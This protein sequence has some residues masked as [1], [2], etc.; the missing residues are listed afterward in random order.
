LTTFTMTTASA[1]ASTKDATSRTSGSSCPYAV[2]IDD[3]DLSEHSTPELLELA[4][5]CPAFEAGNCPFKGKD[6]REALVHI[7]A[8]HLEKD[9]GYLAKAL[10]HLHSVQ[11]SPAIRSEYSIPG[12]CPMQQYLNDGTLSFTRALEDLSLSSIIARMAQDVMSQEEG[13]KKEEMTT[14]TLEL[15]SQMLTQISASLASSQ[16][17]QSPS[18]SQELKSGTAE[19]HQAAEDV[20]FVQNFIRGKIDRQLFADFTLSLYHVYQKLESALDQH[21][22][23]HFNTCH[24]PKELSRRDTLEEDVDFW[25]G[26][27]PATTTQVS[28]ATQDYIDR[29]DFIASTDPL[30]LLAHAYTRYMGDLSGGK[31][32]ARVAKRAMNLSEGDGLAFYEFVN[33]PSSKLFKDLY[34]RSLDD[35]ELTKSEISKIVVEANVAFVLNMRIFEEL[36]VKAN[37]PGAKV[38]SLTEALTMV[39][40]PATTKKNIPDECP[41][42]K[43]NTKQ[44]ATATTSAKRCPWPFV[45]AHDPVQGL[46]DWQTW[47]VVGLLLA[48]FWNMTQTS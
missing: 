8:S 2:S 33:V 34:R 17:I 24:F 45:F 26:S 4:K 18:L 42:A 21:A 27:N 15:P 9:R 41:F 30:L 39:A 19:S 5:K 10:E 11:P 16:E 32:L 25:M 20:H 35:L 12:G 43:I 23:T 13:S 14:P 29:L 48:W 22:P 3:D 47:I 7:P 28:P 44:G 37:I 6:V 31:I 36:D 46:Q 1:S 38:R 40:T